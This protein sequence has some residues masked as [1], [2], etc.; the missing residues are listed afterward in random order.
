MS[1]KNCLALA[2]PLL[3]GL[4]CG[5]SQDEFFESLAEEI[6]EKTAECLEDFE[7][8]T[9]YD[10]VDEC[11]DA[12][13]DMSEGYPDAWTDEEV[14]EYDRDKA[15][16]CLDAIDDV[17]CDDD[18]EDFMEELI[19]AMGECEMDEIFDCDEGAITNDC[20]AAV[21]DITS[22]M[23]SCGVPSSGY[24]EDEEIYEECPSYLGEIMS[25]YGDC[26]NATDCG[27]LDGTDTEALMELASC[28]NAC[29]Y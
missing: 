5:P 1:V 9:G 13:E 19:E 20:Q 14:C 25:C 10:D 23:D 16:D 15:R 18:E 8:Y 3:L 24:L 2:V 22:K 27:A 6:C 29:K 7:D 26:Y 28:M 12:W 4:A 11:S 17:E 21:Q